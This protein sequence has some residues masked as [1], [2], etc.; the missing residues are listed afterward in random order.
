M[1]DKDE[2]RKEGDLIRDGSVLF[3]Q[4]R[5]VKGQGEEGIQKNSS[6]DMNDPVDQMIAKHIELAEIVVEG[7]SEIRENTYRLF[8][9]IFNEPLPSIPGKNLHL[10]IRIIRDIRTV[11]E[12]K[13]D[14]KG[15]G[16]GQPGH[17]DDEADR[18]QMA[19]G[20]S[21]SLRKIFPF[22]HGDALFLNPF[23]DDRINIPSRSARFQS[24]L[25]KVGS[26]QRGSRPWNPASA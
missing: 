6:K 5:K 25:S 12:M 24:G 16:I 17:P 10:N 26:G 23:G 19:G 11:I 22:R 21:C 9:G 18:Y 2:T 4:G 7:Q 15:I 13:G 14:I 8:I 1:G 20:D 3:P